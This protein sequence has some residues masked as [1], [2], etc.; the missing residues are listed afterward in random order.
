MSDLRSRGGS[1]R[2]PTRALSPLL[3]PATLVVLVAGLSSGCVTTA[4]P[5][6]T[7]TEPGR[8]YREEGFASW[9]GD[10]YHG[11][12]TASGEPYDM[13][14]MTAAHRTLPFGTV[15]RV[16]RLDTGRETTVR[17]TDRGPF[18]PGRIIDLSRAAAD[19]LEAIGPGIVRVRLWVEAWGGHAPGSNCWEVQVGAFAVEDNRERARRALEDQGYSV[20]LLPGRGGLTRVRITNLGTR[21]AA[22]A[23]ARRVRRD[24]PDAQPVLCG[25]S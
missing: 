21:D 16:R 7:A 2:G 4:S 1:R 6:G 14:A 12:M 25:D 20:R 13:W 19:A 3:S 18:V 24:F 15:V 11:R 10:P 17:I 5:P 22:A 8:D 9:Y 23:A